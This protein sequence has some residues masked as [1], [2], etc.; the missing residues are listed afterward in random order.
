MLTNTPR[1]PERPD[2]GGST[3]RG[4]GFPFLFE[5][6]RVQ[7]IPASWKP[8]ILCGS[9]LLLLACSKAPSERAAAAAPAQPPG[10]E[11]PAEQEPVWDDTG[12]PPA[13]EAPQEQLPEPS[14]ASR[15]ETTRQW[16]TPE[17]PFDGLTEA[18]LAEL[19]AKR[20]EE[21]GSLSIGLPNSGRLLNGVALAPSELFE[22]VAPGTAYGTQETIDYLTRAVRKVHELHPGTPPLHV[23]DVSRRTGGY[24]SP[25][26][27]HQSGRDVDLGFY[28]KAGARWYARASR[29]NLDVER[30]W[31]LVRALITETDVEMILVDRSI[32][33]ILEEHALRIGE[34]PDWVKSL[35]QARPGRVP[36]LYHV[37][38]HQTHLHVRFY[39]PLAQIGAQ[40]VYPHLVRH[41][42]IPPVVSYINHV[43]KKGDSLIK[44]ARQ[45]GT[46]VRAIQKANGLKRTLIFAKRTYRIP[47][48]GGPP[49]VTGKLSFPPRHL[50][51]FDP[52]GPI[53]ATAGQ[54]APSGAR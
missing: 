11:H 52:P 9:S 6:L 22:P 54:P 24:L 43:A 26:L 48:T 50:P 27:S 15:T 5:D 47:R 30:T 51:P 36:L 29:D 10:I 7:S 34:D 17:H 32:Q 41:S 20:P 49:P 31:T 18:E 13:A 38:G 3:F 23:G 14:G 46:T 53:S 44:L 8:W 16:F 1:P 35:F 2:R 28:Y 4:G 25:H 45:Y 33:R 19:V 40:K 42:L 39:N 21:L 37:K 12:A